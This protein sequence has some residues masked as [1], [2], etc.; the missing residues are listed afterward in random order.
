ML[1]SIMIL[2]FGK[3]AAIHG[4][5]CF[6]IW[7]FYCK[8]V[9]WLLSMP[10]RENEDDTCC[11][12]WLAVWAFEIQTGWTSV[13][14]PPS[15]RHAGW[16]WWWSDL[17]GRKIPRVCSAWYPGLPRVTNLAN[18][19]KSKDEP[20]HY[21][22]LETWLPFFLFVMFAQWFREQTNWYPAHSIFS[23]LEEVET[24]ELKLGILK[25][26]LR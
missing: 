15:S 18:P 14:F 16:W 12:C 6:S 17:P 2:F 19:Y 26:Q 3:S 23:F 7:Y 9:C 25:S 10:R 22:L 11:L 8:Y 5:S 4:H 21:F 20:T 13:C 24:G 1:I